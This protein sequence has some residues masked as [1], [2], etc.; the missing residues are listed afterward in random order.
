LDFSDIQP[1]IERQNKDTQ[2]IAR[3]FIDYFEKRLDLKTLKIKL[4]R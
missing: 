2:E 1:V 3:L 4:T